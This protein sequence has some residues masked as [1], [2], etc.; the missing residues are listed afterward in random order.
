MIYTAVLPGT[1]SAPTSIMN[2]DETSV[3][4]SWEAV[5]D[6]GG[7][8][9]LTGYKVEIRTSSLKYSIAT[10]A[11]SLNST[12]TSCEISIVDLFE[13]PFLLSYED[14]I[15]ARVIAVNVVGDS[16]ASADGGGVAQLPS[17]TTVV[18]IIEAIIADGSYEAFLGGKEHATNIKN[19]DSFI[20]AVEAFIEGDDALKDLGGGESEGDHDDGH[21]TVGIDGARGE[22]HEDREIGD[23]GHEEESHHETG[24]NHE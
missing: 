5:T 15:W 13:A 11:E 18:G 19:G 21:G 12:S 4:V 8:A 7:M 1:P 10:C 24:E 20:D 3:L 14:Y 6:F 16:T 17:E 9:S 2:S 22:G 23:E